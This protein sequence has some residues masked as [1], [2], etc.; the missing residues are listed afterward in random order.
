MEISSGDVE[1]VIPFDVSIHKVRLK[2]VFGILR[3]DLLTV[4]I[5]LEVV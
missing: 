4:I 3:V 1:V 5:V 2:V